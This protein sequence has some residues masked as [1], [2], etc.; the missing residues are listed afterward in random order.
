M[1]NKWDSLFSN[2]FVQQFADFATKQLKT[3][4]K[5]RFYSLCIYF[6]LFYLRITDVMLPGLSTY[7]IFFYDNGYIN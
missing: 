1:N 2:I 3:D 7:V 5:K 6:Q 4:L